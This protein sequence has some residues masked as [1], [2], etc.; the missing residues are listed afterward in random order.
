MVSDQTDEPKNEEEEEEIYQTDVDKNVAWLGGGILVDGRD[1]ARDEAWDE[2]WD[3]AR[4]E[5]W[6]E[7]W[8]GENGGDV[9]GTTIIGCTFLKHKRDRIK[10]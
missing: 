6:D 8:E 1:E 5:A 4:D 10:G 9:H 2:A 7:A 3:E